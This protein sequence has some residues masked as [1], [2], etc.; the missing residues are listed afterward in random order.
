ME[1]NVKEIPFNGKSLLGVK[2]G[3]GKVWLAIKKACI[4]IGLN[5]NQSRTEVKKIQ[6]ALLFKN[7]FE[8]LS[9]KF[10]TQ[11][12]EIVVLSEK[13]VPMWLAQIN[14]TPA[15]QKKNPI[16]V[17]N[18][19]KYQLEAADVLHKAFYETDDQKTAFHEMLGLE[20]KVVSLEQK[21]DKLTGN[22]QE[23]IDNST[24]NKAQQN[25]LYNLA[26]ERI[27]FL[28]G[29]KSTKEYKRYHKLYFQNLW[30]AVKRKFDC[31]GSYHDL[32]PKDFKAV[33]EFIPAWEFVG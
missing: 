2:T 5:E 10:D 17:T 31:S 28:L 13:F 30:G 9:V 18:L 4:D 14:L 7:G 21:V 25:A 32:N 3:D 29:G 19:L 27:C 24:I 33:K 12:R 22:V 11:V 16:A 15:M 20:G 1:S 26:K 6:T 8:K 23:L